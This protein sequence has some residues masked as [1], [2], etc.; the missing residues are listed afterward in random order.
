MDESMKP[1]PLQYPFGQYALEDL[2]RKMHDPSKDLVNPNPSANWTPGDTC[3]FYEPKGHAV[4]YAVVTDVEP[5]SPMHGVNL[6]VQMLDAP[7]SALLR[8]E[9]AFPTLQSLNMALYRLPRGHAG[10]R[11][12][13]THVS[14]CI[15]NEIGLD[16]HAIESILAKKIDER[17]IPSILAREVEEYF[18]VSRTRKGDPAAAAKID[19]MI[20]R[21]V[22]EEV[23]AR[24]TPQ[25]VDRIDAAIRD[26]IPA[27]VVPAPD[28]ADVAV[29]K[30]ENARLE[31]E[32]ELAALKRENARLKA[33]NEALFAQVR[34]RCATCARND[35]DFRKPPCDHC[36]WYA[37]GDDHWEWN[38]GI[39]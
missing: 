21:F 28:G 6:F 12:G 20:S 5:P 13:Y 10:P 26:A 37:G 8:C 34:G 22:H 3:W 16:R 11:I 4:H 38:K 19:Q 18:G 2:P 27:S 15:A 24:M 14:N 35:G 36:Y 1:A 29:L 9:E 32:N 7:S 31:D 39:R 25:V 30:A 23:K 17:D 33:E